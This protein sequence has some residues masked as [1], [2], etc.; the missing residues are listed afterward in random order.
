MKNQEEI[1]T[2]ICQYIAD[3]ID[4]SIEQLLAGKFE[5]NYMKVH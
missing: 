2:A 5:M 4:C 3:S 1:K